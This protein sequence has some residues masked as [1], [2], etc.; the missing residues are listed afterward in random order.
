MNKQENELKVQI[1]I[2]LF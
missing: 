2:I 1:V